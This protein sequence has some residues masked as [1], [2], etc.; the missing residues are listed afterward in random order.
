MVNI[1]FDQLNSRLSKRLD[2]L[3]QYQD[4]AE[5][6]R[7]LKRYLSHFVKLV[8]AGRHFETSFGEHLRLVVLYLNDRREQPLE[9]ETLGTIVKTLCV[10]CCIT[11]VSYQSVMIALH[12]LLD[13]F[14]RISCKETLAVIEYCG[15]YFKK[16]I[17]QFKRF[18]Y[19]KIQRQLVELVYISS[20]SIS[21]PKDRKNFVL[22]LGRL[23]GGPWERIL[24][25]KT[26]AVEKEV[27]TFINGFQDRYPL[28]AAY[29]VP[30]EDCRIGDYHFVRPRESHGGMW[31]DVNFKPAT[32]RFAGCV[33][34]AP[35]G[36]DPLEMSMGFEIEHRNVTNIDWKSENDKNLITIEYNNI[37]VE[38]DV[39]KVDPK[40]SLT[41]IISSSFDCDYLVKEVIPEVRS[42]EGRENDS[43]QPNTTS[44][45]G[46]LNVSLL[47]SV[48]SGPANSHNFDHSPR[49]RDNLDAIEQHRNMRCQM[50]DQTSS[51]ESNKE[52]LEPRRSMSDVRVVLQDV[53]R[54]RVFESLQQECQQK[55][56]S[57][58]LKQSTPE[59]RN[60]GD[61]SGDPQI[62]EG[63]RRK[64]FKQ[65]VQDTLN[66]SVDSQLQRNKYVEK[67][68]VNTVKPIQTLDVK[69]LVV[70]PSAENIQGPSNALNE[71]TATDMMSSEEFEES[72]RAYIDNN[73]IFGIAQQKVLDNK[74]EK[75]IRKINQ[76]VDRS[77]KKFFKREPAADNPYEFIDSG[78]NRKSAKKQANRKGANSTSKRK[79]KA[80][81]ENSSVTKVA[82]DA[83]NQ[84]LR[85]KNAKSAAKKA[86]TKTLS[87]P[88]EPIMRRKSLPRSKKPTLI[89]D[90]SS[91][92]EAE[93]AEMGNTFHN[94][95][96]SSIAVPT[97]AETMPKHPIPIAKRLFAKSTPLENVKN[98]KR[99]LDATYTEE[100]QSKPPQAGERTFSAKQQRVPLLEVDP[101]GDGNGVFLRRD[102]K[103]Q[104]LPTGLQPGVT[105]L[106][107][108]E[109]E[110]APSSV[111]SY[112]NSHSDDTRI[113]MEVPK[114]HVDTPALPPLTKAM[115][116]QHQT[117]MSSASIPQSLLVNPSPPNL[118]PIQEKAVPST[119]TP[120]AANFNMDYA[121]NRYTLKKFICANDQMF[122]ADEEVPARLNTGNE[123][124]LSDEIR[125]G[126]DAAVPPSL[127]ENDS[128]ELNI[129]DNVSQEQEPQTRY[130]PTTPSP[131][132]F[133]NVPDNRYDPRID[134]NASQTVILE[135]ET[136]N[137]KTQEPISP[138]KEAAALNALMMEQFQTRI[139]EELDP[140]LTEFESKVEKMDKMLT[141][142]E[143]QLMEHNFE[144][145]YRKCEE[146][147]EMEDKLDEKFN[148]LAKLCVDA[149]ERAD[150]AAVTAKK[151][152][153]YAD[154]K[155]GYFKE[156][157]Q[158]ALQEIPG[159]VDEHV[160]G[161]WNEQVQ[162]RLN[163]MQLLMTKMLM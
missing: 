17:S 104:H 118:I 94:L 64:L 129:V 107:E 92:S 87:K 98:K 82:K 67:K 63:K 161:V 34:L 157:N 124:I 135:D 72:L 95:N 18:G 154:I 152:A 81:N 86:N 46:L 83:T 12:G 91:D 10:I 89:I 75:N 149:V 147:I 38:P 20:L 53:Q 151:L 45:E 14:E 61:E 15:N 84:S 24:A 122:A 130:Y 125:A 113:T 80:N 128:S 153:Q 59:K 76:M 4:P 3:R 39:L 99:P 42:N 31:L 22:D 139:H 78:G 52:N 33:V 65:T 6:L 11:S 21:K 30:V 90:L 88:S 136:N 112:S 158:M 7:M 133:R 143:P 159:I 54:L 117:S 68:L 123:T 25:W 155:V 27:R 137:T 111:P 93:P 162:L 57:R 138:N 148:E 121:K 70:G 132:P 116:R 108:H 134:D 141:D 114:V 145:F 163:Q 156:Q 19:Y 74:L 60:H 51:V 36:A 142:F 127:Q 119:V 56:M 102:Y 40:G 43:E 1:D 96:I 48:A 146:I 58:S 160:K 37:I 35:G 28:F 120:A 69:P 16:L 5:K 23:I 103:K 26:I 44:I 131:K 71:S 97:T 50:L 9:M 85:N 32:V 100:A 62:N 8:Q 2:Q 101:K 41:L 13:I 55:K 109:R 110:K 47:E 77:S 79:P 29:S 66:E 105:A 140:S 49:L 144:E 115:V 106:L 150:K 73:G 126:C